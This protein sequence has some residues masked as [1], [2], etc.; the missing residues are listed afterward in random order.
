MSWPL[1]LLIVVPIVV[2]SG[3]WLFVVTTRVM[4]LEEEKSRLEE[5]M[6]RIEEESEN[7]HAQNE[8]NIRRIAASLDRLNILEGPEPR[9]VS[10]PVV[11]R[12]RQPKKRLPKG[13]RKTSFE[14]ISEDNGPLD[15][16]EED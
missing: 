7:R 12:Q 14:R 10:V 6:E 4:L 15:E 11:P 3:I 9:S 16:L 5:E 2:T 8:E 13:I 1:I